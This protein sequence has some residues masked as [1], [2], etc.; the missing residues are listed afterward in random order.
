[1]KTGT[2]GAPLFRSRKVL[3]PAGKSRGSPFQNIHHKLNIEHKLNVLGITELKR[4]FEPKSEFGHVCSLECVFFSYSFHEA[5]PDTSMI[6]CS[7][8]TLLFSN[9]GVLFSGHA[10]GTELSRWDNPQKVA[11]TVLW[12]PI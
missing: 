5:M 9:R 3:F 1:M 7:E 8:R 11:Y 2:T 10:D 4:R 6:S 12:T